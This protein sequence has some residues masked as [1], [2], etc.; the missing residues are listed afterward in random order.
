MD[1][2]IEDFALGLFEEEGIKVVL[3][4]VKFVAGLVGDGGEEDW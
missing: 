4:S 3:Y 2:S 1:I